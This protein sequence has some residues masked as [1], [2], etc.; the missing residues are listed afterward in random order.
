MRSQLLAYVVLLMGTTKN[1]MNSKHI[2]TLYCPTFNVN[3]ELSIDKSLTIIN[4]LLWHR[5]VHV[6]R[7]TAKEYV[8]LFDGKQQLTI[9]L[10]IPTFTKKN[11]IAGVIRNVIVS[12]PL[13]PVIT[14]MPALLKRDAFEAAIYYAAQMGAN[15]IQPIITAKTQRSWHG[16]KEFERLTNVMIAACEQA[17]NFTLP[18]FKAPVLLREI[19]EQPTSMNIYFEEDGLSLMAIMQKCAEITPQHMALVFGPEGGLTIEE[20]SFL[21]ARRFICCALTPT[22]LR[23]Q[24][25]IAVGLGSIR[26]LI[27]PK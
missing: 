24:E 18:E 27:N 7:L 8:I 6:L 21:D 3:Q 9:E 25:A 2:F 15:S 5:I 16:D 17:K 14:L 4:Q 13:A 10:S 26:S 22:I 1:N 11:M 12:K 19:E 23:A 20:Q